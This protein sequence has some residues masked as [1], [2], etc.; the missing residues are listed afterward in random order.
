M[1]L[2]AAK[3]LRDEIKLAGYDCIVPLGYGPRGYFARIFGATNKPRDF[4]TLRVFRRFRLKRKME[5]ERAQHE[6]VKLMLQ[7]RYPARSPIEMMIDDA[8]GISSL[9]PHGDTR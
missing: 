9:S 8:C 1:E 5:A 2:K 4:R 6:Y 7:Q 3:A